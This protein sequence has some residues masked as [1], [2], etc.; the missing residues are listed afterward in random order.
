ML[1]SLFA[2]LTVGILQ[3][4]SP[5]ALASVSSP[6]LGFLTSPLLAAS[7]ADVKKMVAVVIGLLYLVWV[8]PMGFV[9]CA[10]GIA[11]LKRQEDGVASIVGG[12]GM[13]IS[14]PVIVIVLKL[15]GFTNLVID[16]SDINNALNG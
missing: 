12:L 3:V 11:A 5:D 16:V 1:T 10:S 2:L 13:I 15:I 8:V 9:Y 6:V 7:M 4:Q 14:L